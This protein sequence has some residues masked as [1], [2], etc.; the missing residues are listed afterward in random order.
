MGLI[1]AIYILKR[2]K[3]LNRRKVDW[4]NIYS[5]SSSL[6]NPFLLLAFPLYVFVLVLSIGIINSAITHNIFFLSWLVIIPFLLRP[7]KKLANPSAKLLLKIDPRPCVLYLRS[8]SLDSEVIGEDKISILPKKSIEEILSRTTNQIGPFVAIA[9]P[10]SMLQSIGA[11]KT[12]FSD[13]EWKLAVHD[14]ML[15]SRFI[16]MLAGDSDA[17]EWELSKIKEEKRE[18]DLLVLFGKPV[19]DK[20]R[21]IMSDS[22]VD[23]VNINKK[24][25]EEAIGAYKKNDDTLV[26]ITGNP[27]EKYSYESALQ[28]FLCERNYC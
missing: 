17:I 15:K 24:S 18:M 16:V 22:N 27:K 25:D 11:A 2:T 6:L 28:L 21:F 23:L 10:K 12:K 19:T 5:V 8:F 20:L 26:F 4:R 13:H 7:I 3:W 9:K 1:I 14:F